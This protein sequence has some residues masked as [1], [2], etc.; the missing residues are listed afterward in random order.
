MQ[1]TSERLLDNGIRERHF[2]LDG[3]AGILWTP[4]AATQTAPVPLILLGHPGGLDALYPR[5]EA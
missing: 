2:L 3:T 5:L 4:P 1:P